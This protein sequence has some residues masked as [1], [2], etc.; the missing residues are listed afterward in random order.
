VSGTIRMFAIFLILS[1]ASVIAQVPNPSE[2]H[3]VSQVVDFWVTNTEQLIL[4]AA[5]ANFGQPLYALCV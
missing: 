1:A 3:T 2:P 4:P 5:E